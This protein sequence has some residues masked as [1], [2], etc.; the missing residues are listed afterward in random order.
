MAVS[1]SYVTAPPAR[2]SSAYSTVPRWVGA[3]AAFACLLLVGAKVLLIWRINVNWDEFYF[4]S[5]VH[6]LLRGDLA[7]VLQT[8]YTHLFVWLPALGNE[9]AQVI[10]GRC[11][12]VLGL[13]LTAWLI[14][15]LASRW[16]S[17]EA[18]VIAP[19]S[20]LVTWHVLR[21]GAS[22]RADSLLAPLTLGVLCFLTQPG[23]RNRSLAA[24]AAC[25][26]LS[27]AVTAKAVLLAPL[28]VLMVILHP[29]ASAGSLG[30]RMLGGVRQL[31]LFG[32]IAAGT[33]GLALLLHRLSLTV[34]DIANGQ[35]VSSL[36]RKTLLEVPFLPRPQP[37]LT[38][39]YEDRLVWLLIVSG[40]VASL[41]RRQY[42]ALACIVSLSPV[43]FYR[44][45]FPY[46]YI[47]MFAPACVLAALAVDFLRAHVERSRGVK[48]AALLPALVIVVLAA[49]G[50]RQVG[51]LREDEQVGERATIAAVHQ[52]FPQPVP[53]IDHSGMMASFVKV[54][55]F[56]STWGVENYRA[57]GVG[58]MQEA[59]ERYRPPLLLVNHG[60]LNPDAGKRLLAQ[61]QQLLRDSYV[62]Y[63]GPIRVAGK[64]MVLSP[65]AQTVAH[66][67][68]AGR[69]RIESEQ[70]IL[71]DGVSRAQNDVITLAEN[72]TDVTLRQAQESGSSLKVRLV[73]ADAGPPPDA[74]FV[75]ST[76]S[77]YTS[78]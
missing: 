67:P 22:F 19:L 37:L 44:N 35:T 34:P 21:H 20:Y 18:A 71:V 68:F 25:F 78:L 32:V 6:S 63:W 14:W 52:I 76:A 45:A 48:I 54:N 62:Q 10:G 40:A 12:M 65:G 42:Q 8:A 9:M 2:F 57:R 73:W 36:A 46:Y 49:Q 64:A 29:P 66:L 47:V 30:S 43:L 51:A 72:D 17:R 26:G 41:F 60:V 27:V 7:F 74:A 33:A 53:Y 58:F 61:D 69:Y 55:F 59:L 70:P 28:I 77:L 31:I 3:L 5:H 38:S 1:E 24:A 4:L 23:L 15:K 50:A 39:W 11:V 16:V 56:M 75:P 13:A